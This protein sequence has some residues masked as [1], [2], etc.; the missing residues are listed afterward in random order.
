MAEGANFVADLAAARA[1]RR[2]REI[3]QQIPQI[4]HWAQ[5]RARHSLLS[6][7]STSR[8]SARVPAELF[9]RHLRSL[10]RDRSAR[11]GPEL[12]LLDRAFEDCLDRLRD[13]PRRFGRALLL[14]CPSPDWPKRLAAH[15][16]VVNVADPGAIFARQAGGLQV[17]EDR[18]D[19]GEDRYD[20]CVAVG[21]L[22]SVNE[23]PLALAL[24]NRALTSDAP[25]I[26]AIAG[27][28]SLVSLRSALVEAGREQ[29][30][31]IART[32]PRVD[33]ASLAQLLAAAQFNMPVVDV[34]RVRLTYS[35]FD[36]LVRDLRAMGATAALAQRSPPMSRPELRRARVLFLAKGA[37]GRT[38]ELME[39][40]HF[41]AW[42]K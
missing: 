42:T 34:D 38:E 16:D 29:G 22:D 1:A 20:L 9:N 18:H 35:S 21:T 39:I 10:R 7:G 2:K 24:I 12:F 36:A 33:S 4:A 6:R 37:N 17:E 3:K 41:L 25:L 26:G 32:H 5:N 19:F 28:N 11:M 30:R 13:I 23:L 27:G 31:I 40:L 15:A 8:T 14:G